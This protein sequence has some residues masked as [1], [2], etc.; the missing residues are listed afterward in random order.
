MKYAF[1]ESRSSTDL[2]GLR[3]KKQRNNKKRFPGREDINNRD[4][5]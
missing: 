2:A 1:I 5:I 3:V 4:G